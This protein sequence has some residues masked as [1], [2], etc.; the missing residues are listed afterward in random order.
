MPGVKRKEGSR[1]IEHDQSDRSKKQ[2]IQSSHQSKTA[3]KPA[4][5]SDESGRSDPAE[6]IDDDFDAF[7][8]DEADDEDHSN[9][10]QHHGSN[11]AATTTHAVARQLPGGPGDSASTS[12]ESHAKQKALAQER[13][14]SKPNADLIARSKK[15]WER[16][17]RKSH[18]PLEER[19]V[20]VKELFEIVTGR[21]K[22]FV[23]KHDAVRVVQTAIK[24]ANL[25]QRKM[26]AS[27]L[28]GEYRQLAESRYAKFLIGKL[29]VHGDAEIRDMIVPEFF[30][31]ARRLI[32][33]PEA[34]WIL[35]DVYR[36]IA[37]PHQKAVLLR[38]WYGAE[39]SLFKNTD[40]E[41]VTSELADIL[42]QSP[43]KRAP[44]LRALHQLVNQ[45]IQKK[46]S[47]FTMLHD[48][49]LQYLLNIKTG[50]EEMT[51]FIELLKG[52]E[53]NDL[54]KNLAFTKSGARVVCL[55]LAHGTAK[56]RKQILR[57]YKDIIATLA[58]DANGH[59]LILT[60]YEVID[61]TVLVS[62][63]IFP[64]I[65][66]KEE[67]TQ[68]EN[69]LN[70]VVDLKARILILYLF[71]G[72]AKWLLPAQD[73]PLLDE[74]DAIRAN[75]SKKDPALRQ[76]ELRKAFSPQLL[77]LSET[78]VDKLCQTSFGCQYLTEI[79]L[80]AEGNKSG[81]L[82]ALAKIAEG[83]PNTEGHVSQSAAAGRMLKTLVHG[84][85]F[86]AQTKKIH[87]VTP[88]LE[89]HNLLYEHI[90]P[91]VMAWATSSSSFVVV[92]L[93][94]AEGFSH[95]EEVRDTL[96]KQR[97]VLE[98]SAIQATEEQKRKRQNEEKA[99]AE[100][101]K[102]DKKGGMA[103]KEVVGNTGAKLLLEKLD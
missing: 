83:D 93:L 49:M 41:K 39:F 84:G 9:S 70:C 21:V 59:L 94:E 38:E 33:H 63:S 13:R 68:E 18:V 65:F 60:A 55:A 99:K 25:E 74:V 47:G 50:S 52:D 82:E 96:K 76:Q 1:N 44:I 48:A 26:I 42:A 89:F 56:D 29:L 97:K 34:S 61:D 35:D 57:A 66:G 73:V 30:G 23:L 85:R 8:A 6:N 95:E 71:A 72:R 79:L 67:S 102:G 32:K 17:R 81:S 100:G 86:D 88:P 28:K 24:Y 53:E 3:P 91:H 7:E 12:R 92:S 16:L 19:K 75:T 69:L 78:Q 31:H 5:V 46:T 98:E 22:D 40:D 51:E 4:A 62:K 90:K 14:A 64:E 27:E 11:G 43:E 58:Y 15:L 103:R 37:T 54:L 45:L 2:K 10:I 87:V 20:L 36:G 101:K 80:G 77:K